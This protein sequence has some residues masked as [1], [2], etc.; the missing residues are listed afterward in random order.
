MDNILTSECKKGL[1]ASLT[2]STVSLVYNLAHSRKTRR[3]KH[4]LGP[5]HHFHN[6]NTHFPLNIIIQ[7]E[8]WGW[9]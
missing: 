7:Q 4:P 5:S 9:P 6:Y 2:N 8:P 1:S 3:H